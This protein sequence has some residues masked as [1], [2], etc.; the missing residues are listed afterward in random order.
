MNNENNPENNLN[1]LNNILFDTLRG[2]Q[3]GSV[4]SKKATAITNVGNSIINN[5]KT[6][7]SAF[8]ATGGIAYQQNFKQLRPPKESVKVAD[9]YTQKT[10]FSRSQGF[11]SITEAIGKMGKAKFENEFKTWIK[12]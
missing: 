9:L 12:E 3:D 10:E 7:L 11:E 4:D 5:A 6:Q 2:L 8:K 1:E